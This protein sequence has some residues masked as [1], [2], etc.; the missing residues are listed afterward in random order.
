MNLEMKLNYLCIKIIID[1]EIRYDFFCLTVH[2]CPTLS[3]CDPLLKF[4]YD[5][6]CM[7]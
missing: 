2:F 6:E 5:S 3:N 4:I 7:S 1:I